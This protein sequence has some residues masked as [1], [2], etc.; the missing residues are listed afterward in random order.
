[1]EIYNDKP[2]KIKA[3]DKEQY[4]LDKAA[5]ARFE[6]NLA[7][8]AMPIVFECDAF[9]KF[10]ETVDDGTFIKSKFC[11]LRKQPSTVYKRG[12]IYGEG[13]SCFNKIF[14]KQINE[15][16]TTELFNPLKSLINRYRT[17]AKE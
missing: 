14:I 9:I 10:E 2:C 4:Y 1:M 5:D 12:D 15:I 16:L 13:E 7:K 11:Y 8:I 6:K 17:T 3:K